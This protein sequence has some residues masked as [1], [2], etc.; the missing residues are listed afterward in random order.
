MKKII[1]TVLILF[2]Y[3]V[4]SQSKFEKG[5]FINNNGNKIACL[6]KNENWKNN[7]ETFEYKLSESDESKKNSIDN[8]SE[9][10]IPDKFKFE[11]H[12]S[13]IDKSSNIDYRLSKVRVPEYE[14]KEVFLKLLVESDTKL[15]V[16]SG[17]NLTRFFFSKNN[18]E[19]V[20]LVYKRY[21]TDL[22]D[23]KVNELFR[24]Q[25]KK[26]LPCTGLDTKKVN[27]SR[28]SLKEYF[29][30]YNECN[31]SDK[32]V[33]KNKTVDY[34]KNEL[35]SYIE[36]KVKV[37]ANFLTNSIK[38]DTK[39]NPTIVG[40]FSKMNIKFGAELEYFLPF[41]NHNWSIV[42]NP[43]YQSLNENVTLSNSQEPL[44]GD[45][46]YHL[47]YKSIETML[48]FRKYFS[49]R[50]NSKIFIDLGFSFNIP[51]SSKFTILSNKTNSL[52]N[53]E[54]IPSAGLFTAGI[55]YKL[56]NFYIEGRY[57]SEQ[58]LLGTFTNVESRLSSASIMV[59]YSLFS[60]K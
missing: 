58:D 51:F 12:L 21:I 31:T 59:A 54:N 9:F 55:G 16:Y 38:D 60:S 4:N 29:L 30:R 11:K 41:N 44:I 52:Q 53:F 19:I 48:A 20:P 49:I 33:T 23:I 15:Y 25:L 14:E 13:K 26:L 47:D 18:E 8:V 36:L 56:N 43:N 1:Y 57:H 5:Y 3:T 40:D 10:S 24:Y 17:T 45:F 28:K 27:Y 32:T 6:I 34:S 37:G 22:G 35:K 42:L 2:C 7:P 46:T 39:L 50:N